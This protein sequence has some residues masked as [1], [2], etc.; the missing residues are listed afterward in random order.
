MTQGSQ[1]KYRTGEH[2]HMKDRSRARNSIYAG[3]VCSDGVDG[4]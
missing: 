2:G 3:I 1:L 4:S